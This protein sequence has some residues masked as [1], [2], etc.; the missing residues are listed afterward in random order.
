MEGDDGSN[1]MVSN[2]PSPKRKTSKCIVLAACHRESSLSHALREGR[3]HSPGG[4]ESGAAS[5]KLA[6]N[7]ARQL[8]IPRS[9]ARRLEAL[10]HGPS[11]CKRQ[12]RSD[13][14]LGFSY[15]TV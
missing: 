11:M 8:L 4:E 2:P 13:G 6:K 3:A 10:S 1:Q 12:K 7:R 9:L 5:Q 15:L 14:G